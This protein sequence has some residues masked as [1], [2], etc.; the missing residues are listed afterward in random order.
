MLHA[1]QQT[2]DSS[3]KDNAAE[4]LQDQAAQLQYLR[5]CLSFASRER[6]QLLVMNK[7]MTAMLVRQVQQQSSACSAATAG[8]GSGCD[9]AVSGEGDGRSA[10]AS[11]T[12][13]AGSSGGAG[14]GDAGAGLFDGGSSRSSNSKAGR[15]VARLRRCLSY[16]VSNEG[17]QEAIGGE[18]MVC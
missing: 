1:I 13:G 3:S 16:E 15:R 4:Q 5:E 12:A 6:D 9:A 2:L 10:D 7:K 18:V 8:G 14:A 11:V 17:V